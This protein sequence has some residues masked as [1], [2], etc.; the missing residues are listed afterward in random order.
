MF[1]PSTDLAAYLRPTWFIDSDHP[2]VAAFAEGA[3]GAETAAAEKARAL[4]YAVRDG[5]R[6]DTYEI[7]LSDESMRAS[8]VL[9]RGIGFCIPKAVLLAAV[10][11]AQGIASRLGFA[12][13]R[14]HLPT[15]RLL[16]VMQD[17]VL[18]YHGYVDLLIEG[19]WVRATPAFNR[20]LCERLNV[21]PLEFDG[22]H[23]ALL[24]QF[25]RAGNEYLEYVND[26]GVFADLPLDQIRAGIEKHHPALFAAATRRE[27]QPGP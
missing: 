21:D 16:E 5:I 11:R 9:A 23:D 4:Y 3:I 17:D 27:R 15:D 19:D 12:D 22:R 7:E 25:D 10:A 20:S 8:A 13:V 2:A 1:T 24:Q 14:N 6:Y 26:R 18:V